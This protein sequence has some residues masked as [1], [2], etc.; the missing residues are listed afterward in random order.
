[1]S[2]ISNVGILPVNRVALETF[3]A[4]LPSSDEFVFEKKKAVMHKKKRKRS[5]EGL[6]RAIV[7]LVSAGRE[8]DSLRD[9]SLH[10][11]EMML[12]RQVSCYPGLSIPRRRH[13]TSA[14]ARAGR[15]RLPRPDDYCMIGLSV[16]TCISR[17]DSS[18][19]SPWKDFPSRPRN[20]MGSH[21]GVNQRQHEWRR[22][23][24]PVVGRTPQ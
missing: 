17:P 9:V 21:H 20:Q 8:F 18:H 19:P 16:C 1:M 7:E 11:E 15:S 12:K 24:P 22:S 4:R 6:R 3:S 14:R 5:V 23:S 10:E 13:A 2:G